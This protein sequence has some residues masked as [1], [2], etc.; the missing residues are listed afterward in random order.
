M[1]GEMFE[2]SSGEKLQPKQTLRAG[3]LA[4][5]TE[6]HLQI[7]ERSPNFIRT[8]TGKTMVTLDVGPADTITMLKTKIQDK[9]GILRDQQRLFYA[10]RALG[11]ALKTAVMANDSKSLSCASPN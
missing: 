3:G 5:G 4:H 2:T 1:T 7:T 6:V 9:E 8:M 10:G 11:V